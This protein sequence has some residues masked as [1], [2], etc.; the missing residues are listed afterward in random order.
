MSLLAGAMAGAL[1]KTAIAPLDRTKI[2][3]QI[4]N[5][6]YTVRGAVSFIIHSYRNEGFLSLWRGNSATMARIIPY[7]AIQFSAHEQWKR[8]LGV[9]HHNQPDDP[10]RRYIAGAMAGVTSQSLTYPL[11]LAR[12]RMAVTQKQQYSSLKEVFVHMMHNEGPKAYFR[13]YVPTVLGVIPYAG[14]SFFTYGTLKR[15]HKDW[16]CVNVEI[17]KT[18]EE[19]K[20]LS[21]QLGNMSLVQ[22]S[23]A[24]RSLHTRHGMHLS[25]RGKQWLTIKIL[26]AAVVM[27]T[28]QPPPP[29]CQEEQS[30]SVEIIPGS[31]Q[32]SPSTKSWSGNSPLKVQHPVT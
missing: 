30:T 21:E 23:K 16:S 29:G 1:A 11:D 6:R 20:R 32:A 15:W 10:V 28:E 8:V 19:L 3:F 24:D 27:T 14:T 18:N 2:N 4:S 17:R 5:T 25:L 13:G 26:E 12:A 31:L 9:D 7:A 22:V